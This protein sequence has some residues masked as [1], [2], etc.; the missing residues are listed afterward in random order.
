M[1]KNGFFWTGFGILV[2]LAVAY[3][4]RV[5]IEFGADYIVRSSLLGVLIFHNVF[6]FGI[7]VLVGLFF[8]WKGLKYKIRWI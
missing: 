4:I 3:F 5:P 8:I 2:F 7:Y 6:V 1:K